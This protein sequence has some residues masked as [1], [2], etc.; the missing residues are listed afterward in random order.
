MFFATSVSFLAMSLWGYTTK[1]DLSG[2]GTFLLMGVVGLFVALLINMF[3]R[4]PAIDLA[5]REK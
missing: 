2:F 3:L 5:T 1:R 4:S